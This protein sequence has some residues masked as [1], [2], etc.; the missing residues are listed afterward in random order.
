MNDIKL[1]KAQILHKAIQSVVDDDTVLLNRQREAF[2]QM[3]NKDVVEISSGYFR[4]P[5]A[6]GKTVMFSVMSRA[7]LNKAENATKVVILVPRLVLVDQTLEKL[8]EFANTKGSVYI[9]SEKDTSADVIVSTYR[10]AER[11]FETLKSENQDVGLIIADEAHHAIGEKISEIMKNALENTPVIG[12]TATPT[13]SED[14]ALGDVL[15]YEIYTLSIE[16]C[17]KEGHLCPIKNILYRPSLKF[18]ILNAPV[19]QG[20][21]ADFDYV[22]LGQLIKIQS[23]IDEIAHIYLEDGDGD[24]KFRDMRAIINCPNVKI[25]EEQAKKINELAGQDVAVAVH[26]DQKDF[27]KKVKEFL[28]KKFKVVCQVNTLTEGLD[29]TSVEL[30][31]NYPSYSPVKIEQSGGRVL[32]IDKDNPNKIGYILDAVFSANESESL[33]TSLKRAF[34]AGQVLYRDIAGEFVVKPEEQEKTHVDSNYCA[35]PRKENR[36]F[37]LVSDEYLLSRINMNYNKWNKQDS[38]LSVGYVPHVDE[39][40][41]MGPKYLAKKLYQPK[42]LSCIK[43]EDVLA[44]MRWLQPSMPYAIQLKMSKNNRRGLY[45]KDKFY[46]KFLKNS[47][48]KEIVFK[49]ENDLSSKDV[50]ELYCISAKEAKDNII[51]FK[52]KIDAQYK[53]DTISKK[54]V[55]CFDK[56]YISKV[57]HNVK[58]RKKRPNSDYIDSRV[59]SNKY[60]DESHVVINE[61]LCDIKNNSKNKDLKNAIKIQ[62]VYSWG[63]G[64]NIDDAILHKDF[65]DMFC[66]ESGLQKRE[67]KV[68]QKRQKDAGMQKRKTFNTW[69]TEQDLGKYIADSVTAKQIHQK[70]QEFSNESHFSVQ[71]ADDLKSY[72]FNIT[73]L[74]DFCSFAGWSPIA[75]PIKPNGWKTVYELKAEYIDAD[76]DSILKALKSLS[77]TDFLVRGKEENKYILDSFADYDYAES[78]GYLDDEDIDQLVGV[79]KIVKNSEPWTARNIRVYMDPRTNSP[80]LCLNKKYVKDFIKATGLPAKVG[81]VN[82]K[83]SNKLAGALNNINQKQH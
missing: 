49:T 73:Y 17:V 77:G 11:L 50:S 55:L 30:C 4:L 23:L 58:R 46:D 64:K 15:P 34:V 44:K 16:D 81:F 68:V 72:V 35:Q 1:T 41:D 33:E 24:K 38:W 14:H 5:T 59:L 3:A 56:K 60:V 6:F 82:I 71:L 74:N 63:L 29:D 57:C 7:F 83:R 53:F 62:R 70:L 67:P 54:F 21:D 69:K 43:P 61:K 66:Q 19:K 32:R 28:S 13:F 79:T 37:E 36:P 2:L 10:S 26:S 75:E 65:I 42:T 20:S 12:F 76:S 48:F 78:E 80:E 47:G 8:K 31:V 25:A 45:L 18:N 39:M 9:G 52:D 22:K 40:H 27:D 51:K